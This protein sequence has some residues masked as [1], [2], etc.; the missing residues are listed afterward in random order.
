METSKTS[1][2]S[3][4]LR[5]PLETLKTLRDEIRVQLHLAGLEAKERW[6][7]LESEFRDLQQSAK[8]RSLD[9]NERVRDLL[10]EFR[11]FKNALFGKDRRA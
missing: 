4:E 6:D 3:N 1:K 7:I 9:T 10:Q 8:N 2:T 11:E 5:R